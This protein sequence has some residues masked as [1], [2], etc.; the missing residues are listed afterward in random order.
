MPAASARFEA[1]VPD[2][3]VPTATTCAPNAGSRQASST[4][5]RVVPAPDASTTRRAG[6]AAPGTRRD[7][8]PARLAAGGATG[9]SLIGQR[10]DLAAP[11]EPTRQAQPLPAPMGAATGSEQRGGSGDRA[12]LDT[13]REPGPPG[14]GSDVGEPAAEHRAGGGPG[15]HQDDQSGDRTGRR[16]DQ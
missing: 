6:T 16:R 11:G 13:H 5:C 8:D 4:A 7:G 1:S 14:G 10:D 9:L 3:S 15:G 2:R 12:H